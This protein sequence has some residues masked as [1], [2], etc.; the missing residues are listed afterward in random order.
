MA[1]KRKRRRAIVVTAIGHGELSR[2]IIMMM[3]LQMM[4]MSAE[5]E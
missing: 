5:E 3:I 1:E 2:A 4:K